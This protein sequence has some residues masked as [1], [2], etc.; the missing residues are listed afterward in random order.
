MVIQFCMHVSHFIQPVQLSVPSICQCV[1]FD[2]FSWFKKKKK[3]KIVSHA[4]WLAVCS[5]DCRVI[6]ELLA[7]LSVMYCAGLWGKARLGGKGPQ[8]RVKD[9]NSQTHQLHHPLS[10]WQQRGL[11]VS[12]YVS[13]AQSPPSQHKSTISSLLTGCHSIAALSSLS[14]YPWILERGIA[15]EMLSGQ[16]YGWVIPG[17]EALHRYQRS[18]TVWVLL[19]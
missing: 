8:Q 2:A 1:L 9:Q 17:W 4:V 6:T 7:G 5:R 18:S 19:R 12:Q 3:K 16:Q 14:R 11:H 10:K 15:G 13:P